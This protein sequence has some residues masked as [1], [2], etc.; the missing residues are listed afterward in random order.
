VAFGEHRVG[1]GGL[2]VSIHGIWV[3]LSFLGVILFCFVEFSY[4]VMLNGFGL[5]VLEKIR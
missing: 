1:L 5:W 4:V 2:M 3:F